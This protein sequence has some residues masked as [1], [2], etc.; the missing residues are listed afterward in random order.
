MMTELKLASAGDDIKLWDCNGYTLVKQFNPHS[1]N[2][3]SISWSH[4]NASLASASVGGDKI[5]ISY[6]S[7][8]DHTVTLSEGE[9]KGRTC[10]AFNSLSRYLM[11]GGPDGFIYVWDLKTQKIKKDYKGLK[12]PVTTLQ[13]NWNDTVIASGSES[14]EIMVY[15]VITGLGYTPLTSPKAQAV[16]QI[17]YSHFKKSLLA[18]VSD[19]GS[20]YLWD[21]NTKRI[22]HCFDGFHKAP[23]TGLAFSPLNEML[24]ISVGLDKS[25]ICYDVLCK[26][27]V[28]IITSE[29]ALTSIDLSYDGTTVAVGSTRGKVYIYDL[30]HGTN[31]MRVLAAHKSSVHCLQFQNNVK[32]A[33][34][35]EPVSRMA[36]T[37][38]SA[39]TITTVPDIK[40]SPSTKFNLTGNSLEFSSYSAT[41]LIRSSG[42][43]KVSSEQ[44]LHI[45][46]NGKELDLGDMF[47]P[48]RDITLSSANGK[49]LNVTMNNDQSIADKQNFIDHKT[50][51]MSDHSFGQSTFDIHASENEN[52]FKDEAYLANST[53]SSVPNLTDSLIQSQTTKSSGE[54]SIKKL[55]F[56]SE[57]HP[58]TSRLDT[59]L[60]QKKEKNKSLTT[61][62][63]ATPS[64]VDERLE[65]SASATSSNEEV[66]SV[67]ESESA[68]IPS[69]PATPH[70]F[71]LEFILSAVRD[72]ME[73]FQDQI[74]QDVLNMHVE[75]LKQFQIQ[76]MEIKSLLET[77]SVNPDLL[78]EIQRLREEN[79][80][81]KKNY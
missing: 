58:L 26:T 60:D 14:G 27:P 77:Y 16:R 48:I 13:F 64:A 19:D 9:C 8:G 5:V 32:Q 21:T 52:G 34:E 54:T 35:I 40:N 51:L 56:P 81:L 17:Q 1:N 23:A 36:H 45:S 42:V 25:I 4:D 12:G 11:G 63:D 38:A 72:E 53:R 41:D 66:Y 73:D 80:R 33:K 71:P 57:E 47:S 37:S 62:P 31:P 78:A 49:E 7:A 28:K 46:A 76:T 22:V 50:E 39:T 44:D 30:R 70:Q 68:A 3:S 65:E 69:N 55:G 61:P 24:L 59:K 43:V 2:V 15:N 67:R 10:L 74:R 75:M 18:S 6:T 79:A 20:T 29:T